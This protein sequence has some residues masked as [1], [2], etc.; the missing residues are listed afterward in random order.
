GAFHSR[1]LSLCSSQV[2]T[3]PAGRR[4]RWSR[5]RRLALALSLLRDPV[6]DL[7]LSGE[8][9]FS[10]LPEL[11]ARLAASSTGGLCHTVRYD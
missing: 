3:V 1:R 8:I 5:R 11:M 2:G 9:D 4:Q 10:A 6:F 7:L